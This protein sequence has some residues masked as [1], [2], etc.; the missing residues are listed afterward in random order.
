MT[1]R[2]SDDHDLRQLIFKNDKVIVKFIDENC[3]VCKLLAPSF[4]NFSSDPAYSD[5]TFVRMNASENPVSS[6]EVR[7]TGTPFFAIYR[8]GILRECGLVRTEAEIKV[9]LEKLS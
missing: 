1:I 2:E 6:Q 5:I 3:A 8:Q 7:L 4:A 9:L